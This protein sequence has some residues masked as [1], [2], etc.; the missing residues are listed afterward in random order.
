MKEVFI[1]ETTAHMYLHNNPDLSEKDVC[2]VESMLTFGPVKNG[3]TSKERRKYFKESYPDSDVESFSEFWK[4]IEECKNNAESLLDEKEIRIWYS[5][6]PADLAGFY[7]L[8]SI[9]DGKD[10]KVNVIYEGDYN[11]TNKKPWGV[12]GWGS[13]SFD[14][15]EIKKANEVT[16][17]LSKEQI[18]ETAEK[19]NKLREENYPV[20]TV[21]NGEL[22]SDYPDYRDGLTSVQRSILLTMFELNLKSEGPA[23]NTGKVIGTTMLHELHGDHLIYSNI[24]NLKNNQLNP[25]SLI[26]GTTGRKSGYR[27]EEI[28]LSKY[29]EALLKNI[30]SADVPFIESARAGDRENAEYL[31]GLFPNVFCNGRYGMLSHDYENVVKMLQAFIDNPDINEDKL[32]ELIGL[33]KFSDGRTLLN[34]EVLPEIY[35]TGQGVIKYKAENSDTILEEKIEYRFNV[36]GFVRLL[37]LQSLVSLYIENCQKVQKSRMRNIKNLAGEKEKLLQLKQ[38]V[39]DNYKDIIYMKQNY[40]SIEFAFAMQKKYGFDAKDLEIADRMTLSELSDLSD[41]IAK[42]REYK[43][44]LPFLSGEF[45][46]NYT[47]LTKENE[48]TISK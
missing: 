39:K 30:Y 42:C 16:R 1:G 7:Y 29:G 19:W 12:S 2:F 20:R 5:D 10:I 34:S 44:I 25:Y 32:I 35:K 47:D 8:C 43:V 45:Q 31:P 11:K 36:N 38:T 9:L 14:A 6:F 18:H 4:M 46:S 22:V 13:F 23:A 24:L 21:K 17:I 15:E 28:K 37:S 41:E 3:L 48:N 26:T 27:Y 33:P 40:S